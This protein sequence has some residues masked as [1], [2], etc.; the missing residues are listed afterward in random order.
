MKNICIIPAR[1]GSKR[2]PKKNIKNFLGVP[3]IKYSIEAAF[4]TKLFKDVIV[5]TDNEEISKLSSEFGASVPFTRPKRI[6]N[7]FSGIKEVIAHAIDFFKL[8]NIQ[9]DNICCLFATAPFARVEEIKTGFRLLNLVEKDRFVFTAAKF[10]FPIQR[11][12][13][14]DNNKLALPFDKFATNERSQDLKDYYHDAGQFYWGT[15]E[16][17]L[18]NKNFFEGSMPLIIPS[19]RVQDIDTL[20]DWQRAE[21]IYKL[22]LNK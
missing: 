5:S 3:I 16:A 13:C 22:T 4:N 19:W 21:L 12:F 20:E 8:R 9:I 1:G 2:I 7:D 18:S 10:S 15:S 17:W 11:S 6:S 14:L